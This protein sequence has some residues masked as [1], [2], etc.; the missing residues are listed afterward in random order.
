M[1]GVTIFI[2]CLLTFLLAGFTGVKVFS[3]RADDVID[4]NFPLEQL[5]SFQAKEDIDAVVIN[6]ENQI[7]LARTKQSILAL[8]AANGQVLW[9]VELPITYSGSTPI[10]NE[11][12]VVTTHSQGTVAFNLHTG[13][14]LWEAAD[15]TKSRGRQAFPAAVDGNVVVIIGG[16][17]AIRDLHT[18]QLLWRVERDRPGGD[19]WAVIGANDLYVIFLNQ[20]RS[21]T[22][23]TGELNWS[24]ETPFWSLQNALLNNNLLYL[25]NTFSD[26]VGA[27]DVQTQ[28]LIW[29][30]EGSFTTQSNPL[31]IY[32]DYLFVPVDNDIPLALH[33]QTGDIIW[34]ASGLSN[35]VYSAAHVID[36]VV[37]VKA[38]LK[39]KLYAVELSTGDTIGYL[40]LGQESLFPVDRI[41]SV[42][43][44][45]IGI[46]LIF[47]DN[48]RI[49]A[50]RELRVD[51]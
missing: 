32:E 1:I 16:F 35:D 19:A 24:V 10:V 27:F 28:K 47:A 20:I 6:P 41:S 31:N 23:M 7:I 42:G 26:G 18:G 9:S 17:I 12:V 30:Q 21:Y 14:Q 49:F 51:N 46:S 39:R 36:D 8:D 5:W 40:E 50:Y 25:E 11:N 38:L 13:A 33:L 34:K 3:S 4:H 22:I 48:E 2:A 43:P 29:Q 37:Y 15:N 45:S 44:F